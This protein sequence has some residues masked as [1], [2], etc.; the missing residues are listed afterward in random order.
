[1]VVRDSVISPE[2]GTQANPIVIYVDEGWSGNGTDQFGSDRDTEVM[3]TPEFWETLIGGNFAVHA[4]QGD[5]PIRSLVC[6][7]P[8]ELQSSEQSSPGCFDLDD[9]A[10]KMTESSSY[11]LLNRS[12]LEA[13]SS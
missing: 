10:L 6:E 3:T 11:R 1:M 4:D 8:E 5:T 9:N 13:A 12:G 2:L 7:D